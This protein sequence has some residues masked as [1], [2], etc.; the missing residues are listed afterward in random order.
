[1]DPWMAELI[2]DSSGVILGWAL[3]LGSALLVDWRK[4]KKK[5]GSVKTA[6]SRELREVAH[7]LLALVYKVEG[8]RGRL[9]RQL[10]E[11]MHPHVQRYAGPNPSEGI[12]AGVKGL[13]TQSDAELAQLAAYLQ[14]NAPPRFWPREEPSYTTAA[15]A[16]AHELDPD[17][18]VR[19]LDILSHIRMLN[20]ARENGLY[21]TRLTFVPGITPGNHANAVQN[22]D[23]ADDQMAKRA[24]IIVDKVTALE[25]KY[26]GGPG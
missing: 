20:D 5:V 26:P 23:G 24:R 15:V 10:L 17:Y 2:K 18:A 6:I 21:Y 25:Q 1:M 9:D 12:L 8:R 4:D 3:G 7:R 13:L 16:K 11:W 19:V 14:A 22:A